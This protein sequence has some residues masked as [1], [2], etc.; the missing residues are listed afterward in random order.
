MVKV[1]ENGYEVNGKFITKEEAN[2]L[3]DFKGSKY[4][5]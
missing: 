4:I 3:Q 1:V 5:I 2:E